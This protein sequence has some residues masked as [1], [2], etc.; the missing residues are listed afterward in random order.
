MSQQLDTATVNARI[1]AAFDFGWA[2]GEVSGRTKVQ[3]DLRRTLG[4]VDATPIDLKPITD[5]GVTYALLRDT[6]EFKPSS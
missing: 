3:A 4:V 5:P 1:K 6:L 2:H